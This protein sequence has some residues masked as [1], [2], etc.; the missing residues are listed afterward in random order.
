VDNKFKKRF[1]NEAS[2]LPEVENEEQLVDI[3]AIKEYERSQKE[4]NAPEETPKQELLEFDQWWDMRKNTI[5]QPSYI[6]DILRVDAKA[7]K[8]SKLEPIERWDW[9]ARQFGLK[10]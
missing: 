4:K 8:L 5:D 1:Q 9:A 7:R 2:K 3:A 10:F 6:K